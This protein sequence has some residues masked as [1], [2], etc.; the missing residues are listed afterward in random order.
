MK[1]LVR[2]LATATTSDKIKT[3]F[4]EY[5]TVQSCNLVLDQKTGKS[6]GFGF[7]EMPKVGEAKTAMQKLNGYKLAGS[8]IRVKKAQ[9]SKET[10]EKIA[11]PPIKTEKVAKIQTIEKAT[12]IEKVI[13]KTEKVEK[14]E[15]TN[16]QIEQDEMLDNENNALNIYGKIKEQDDY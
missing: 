13:E 2:N 7:V 11:T 6:K 16:L 10:A 8:V 14:V 9:I 4:S 5:G 3:L 1:L 12:V 15:K